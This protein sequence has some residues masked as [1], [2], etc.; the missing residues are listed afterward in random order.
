MDEVLWEMPLGVAYQLTAVNL[1][2]KGANLRRPILNSLG[3]EADEIRRLLG[4]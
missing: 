2:K 1:W 4:V 3:G